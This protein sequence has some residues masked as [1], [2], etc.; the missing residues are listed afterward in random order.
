MSNFGDNSSINPSIAELTQQQLFRLEVL[1]RDVDKLTL[2]Q[3][4]SY[5]VELVTQQM[6]RDNMYNHLLKHNP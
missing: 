4:K 3:A 6:L 5:L 2:P 1:K